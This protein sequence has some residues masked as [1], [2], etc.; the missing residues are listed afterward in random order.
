MVKVKWIG[1]KLEQLSGK[2]YLQNIQNSV[3]LLFLD[4][5]VAD[6]KLRSVKN[7]EDFINLWTAF[8]CKKKCYKKMS[9]KNSKIW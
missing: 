6:S 9:L 3:Y 8:V 4:I 2:I 7:R 1:Y 5:A